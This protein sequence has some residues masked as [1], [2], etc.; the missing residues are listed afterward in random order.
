MMWSGI[1]QI[2][3]ES[4]ENLGRIFVPKCLMGPEKYE[5]NAYGMCAM[6]KSESPFT[7]IM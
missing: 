1:P 7:S 2:A 4:R 5:I 6:Y 3:F